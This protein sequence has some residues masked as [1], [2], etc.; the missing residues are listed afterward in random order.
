MSVPKSRIKIGKLK[1]WDTGSATVKGRRKDSDSPWLIF[2]AF[3]CFCIGTKS[4]ENNPTTILLSPLTHNNVFLLLPHG[5]NW[6]R[7]DSHLINER[8]TFPIRCRILP[9]SMAV[10]TNFRGKK[11]LL[12]IAK[13][14]GHRTALHMAAS[15]AGPLSPFWAVAFLAEDKTHLM[16][17]APQYLHV[18]KRMQ[19]Q[20]WL[21][22]RKSSFNQTKP[23]QTHTRHFDIHWLVLKTN[24]LASK[25][26]MWFLLGITNPMYDVV[27][28]EH[29]LSWFCF[30]FSRKYLKPI[31]MYSSLINLE[32][33]M[34]NP[35]SP[36][37]LI[38]TTQ[39]DGFATFLPASH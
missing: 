11:A 12:Q 16:D 31:E 28:F 32:G 27:H 37:I 15:S 9:S 23:N 30:W 26:D 18:L 21:R 8:I 19:S 1:S 20:L 13:I 7:H 6:Y 29:R 17:V 5:H 38:T 3:L 14:L 2:Q 33:W 36:S 34:L 10:S 4:V 25:N 22:E 35:P 24:Q 39:Q